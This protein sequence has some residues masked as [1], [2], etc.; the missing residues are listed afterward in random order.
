MSLRRP[1]DMKNLILVI[2]RCAALGWV[3]YFLYDLIGLL[4]DTNSIFYT[5]TDEMN[6]MME[7]A[8][9]HMLV[10]RLTTIGLGVVVYLLAPLVARLATAGTDQ[11]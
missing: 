10:Q 1:T 5:V 11:K 3:G 2:L 7:K 9:Q 8:R 4:T 6:V